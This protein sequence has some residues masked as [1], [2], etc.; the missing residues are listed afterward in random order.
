[1]LS[2]VGGVSSRTGSGLP[3][4]PALSSVFMCV[5]R[6]LSRVD[7]QCRSRKGQIWHICDK[8]TQTYRNKEAEKGRTNERQEPQHLSGNSEKDPNFLTQNREWTTNQRNQ[9]RY[10]NLFYFQCFYAIK[11][12]WLEATLSKWSHFVLLKT[13]WFCLKMPKIT[14]SNLKATETSLTYQD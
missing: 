11:I 13:C 6:G 4:L 10:I 3:S 14:E 12:R 7:N 1:M 5:L 9:R 8:W 2:V